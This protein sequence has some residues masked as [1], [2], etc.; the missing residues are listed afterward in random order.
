[1]FPPFLYIRDMNLMY[2]GIITPAFTTFK[3]KAPKLFQFYEEF[4]M[5][6]FTLGNIALF[7]FSDG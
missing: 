6:Y 5:L 2:E 1:M 4:L 7:I 3:A